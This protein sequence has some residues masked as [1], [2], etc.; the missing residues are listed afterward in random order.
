M[1]DITIVSNVAHACTVTFSDPQL[2]IAWVRI[3]TGNLP[4]D[5][6]SALIK[7]LA[8]EHLE[9]ARQMIFTCMGT[10]A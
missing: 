3:I 10:S 4:A 7:V 9:Q 2:A 6:Y 8:P 1:A 5:A